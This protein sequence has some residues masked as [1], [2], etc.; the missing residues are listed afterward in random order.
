M[1]NQIPPR[2]PRNWP[3]PDQCFFLGLLAAMRVGFVLLLL[4]NSEIPMLPT[5]TSLSTQA[6]PGNSKFNRY[7]KPL[8]PRLTNPQS[9]SFAKRT[10]PVTAYECQSYNQ[11]RL[12]SGKNLR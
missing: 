1:K 9:I 4:K 7:Q 3:E 2:P 6:L 10:I 11:T 8:S 5:F 12:T